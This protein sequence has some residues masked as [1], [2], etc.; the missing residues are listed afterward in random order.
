MNSRWHKT[1]LDPVKLG[2][3]ATCPTRSP[4][5]TA[6]ARLS[7][8]IVALMGGLSILANTTPSH[9]VTLQTISSP[10]GTV[11]AMTPTHVVW[12][13]LENVGTSVI[14]DPNA[15]YLNSLAHT[16]GLATNDYAVAHPSLPN[17]LALTS[18]STQ[19]IH[20]DYEPSAHR[21]GVASIFSELRTNWR[22]YAQSMPTVCDRVTSGLYAAR[23]NPAVYYTN[24]NNCARNDVPLTR[25]LD[26]SKAFTMIVPDVC[27]DM[28]SCSVST[29]DAFLKDYV[30]RV[31]ASP[32]YRARRVVLFITV[33]ENTRGAT[34]R[35]ATIVVAPS[36]PH[37]L[38]VATYFTHYSLLGTTEA[39]L[40]LPLLGDARHASSLVASFHL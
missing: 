26:L 21:L 1:E 37:G 28:H 2:S 35:V 7:L 29:G 20:D 16:C 31:V 3:G 13:I 27:N 6:S 11:R 5:R 32:E 23:H 8:A 14:G 36:V 4:R 38:R 12:I 19:G 22:V 24:L 15:P 39:L 9:G 34:N 33:D 40:H 17:Y 18:G 25:S 10:C 30:K